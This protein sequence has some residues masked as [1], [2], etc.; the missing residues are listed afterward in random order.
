MLLVKEGVSLYGLQPESLWALDVATQV[1]QE[2]AGLDCVLTSGRG[3][4][5]GA[6]SHHYKG[7]AVDLRRRHVLDETMLEEIVKSIRERL[8]E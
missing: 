3:G 4:K 6:F 5:H 8:G 1:F 2:K 7:L